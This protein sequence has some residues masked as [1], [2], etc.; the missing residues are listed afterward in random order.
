VLPP[1]LDAVARLAFEFKTPW[2]RRP[3]DFPMQAGGR[4][5]AARGMRLMRGR[6]RCVLARH[7]CRSTDWFAGFRLTGQL[8]EAD[9]VALIHALPEGSTEFMCHPGLLG[10]ELRQARTRL[11]ES[12]EIELRALKAPRV[13]E[14]LGEAGVRLVSF[15]DLP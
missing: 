14:A 15:R 5:W 12:R 13:R 2:V 11:K 9:L 3:F 6:F 1:V 4:G 7:Q 8:D 10:G